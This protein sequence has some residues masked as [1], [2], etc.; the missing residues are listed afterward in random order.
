MAQCPAAIWQHLGDTLHIAGRLDEAGEAYS[1]ALAAEPRSAYSHYNLAVTRLRQNRLEE[2]AAGFERALRLKPDY[3]EAHMNLGDIRQAYGRPREAIGSFRRAL[4]LRPGFTDAR[5]NLALVL[6]E[7]GEFEEA[8]G[9]YRHVLAHD[10]DYAEA[11]NNAG[12]MLL[13]LGR[14]EQAA[15]SYRAALRADPQH[16][17]ANWNLGVVEL[18]LG[19]FESGWERYEWRLRQR[20]SSPGRF[21]QPLWD[22]SPLEG[23]RLL[24]HAEQGLGD[25]IQFVRFANQAKARGGPVLLECQAQLAGLLARAGGVSRIA[26]REGEFELHAPLMSLPR[27]LKSAIPSTVPYLCADPD[28]VQLWRERIGRENKVKIGLAWGGNPRHKND[29]NRSMR[30]TN[31]ATLAQVPGTIFFSLQKGPQAREVRDC[32]AGLEIVDLQDHLLDFEH[33]AA[34]IMN[35]DLVISVDTAVAHLAGALAKPVWTLLPFA[36]D[37]RWMAARPDSPWYPTMRLFRQKTRGDWDAVIQDVREA[38]HKA[39][40]RPPPLVSQGRT[41]AR[42]PLFPYAFDG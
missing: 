4:L 32:P 10:P 20:E 2:A 29:T 39:V 1:K 30:L 34:A 38:L 31:L 24:L 36:P 6:Q 35:L 27:I 3:A 28:L 25:T 40:S 9:E 41:G 26:N 23:R 8:L 15:A 14:P 13:A 7:Q 33:T 42:E 19:D 5:Y 21:T 12:T 16:P 18:L 11:H 37:W 17:E 22:G